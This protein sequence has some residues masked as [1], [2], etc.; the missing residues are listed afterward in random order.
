S[1]SIHGINRHR[2]AISRFNQKLEPIYQASV[3]LL[4]A[5]VQV[6]EAKAVGKYDY[7][8]ASG[9]F[10]HS[11][12]DIID[13]AECSGRKNILSKFVESLLRFNPCIFVGWSFR[14]LL[15]C[16]RHICRA[17][18]SLVGWIGRLKYINTATAV[19]IP[20]NTLNGG[21]EHPFIGCELL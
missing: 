12:D 2:G 9:Q 8:L 16:A 6:I 11:F 1:A 14:N 13:C 21:I 7:S 15:R 18:D 20:A 17:S 5:P 19:G 10:A 3:R 4:N